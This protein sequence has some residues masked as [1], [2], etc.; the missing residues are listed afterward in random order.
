MS[1]N[2]FAT[3]LTRHRELAGLTQKQLAGRMNVS[4][5]SVNRWESGESTPKRDNAERLDTETEAGGKLFAAWRA[6]AARA[7]LPDWAQNLAEIETTARHATFVTAAG[8]PGLLQSPD[9]A[10]MVFLAGSPLA[11]PEELAHLVSLR[12]DRLAE[13]P[14]LRISATFPATAVGGLPPSLRASQAKHLLM[15]AETG[16]VTLCLTPPGAAMPLP[17]APV[18]IYRLRSGERVTAS[19]HA[20]GTVELH[21][22]AADRVDAVVTSVLSHALPVAS[23]LEYLESLI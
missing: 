14:D 9:Y 11:T 2:L 19:D 6:S 18:M 10:R 22:D 1:S 5:S 20:D 8:V 4:P 21:P 3:A 17:V 12:C 13:L 7:G 16:R 23:S 15:W